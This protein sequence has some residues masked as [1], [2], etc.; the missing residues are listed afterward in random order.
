MVKHDADTVCRLSLCLAGL[1]SPAAQRARA[2]IAPY[3]GAA[4]AH[5]G[6]RDRSDG[7]ARTDLARC[8]E[9]GDAQAA[10]RIAEDNPPGAVGSRLLARVGAALEARGHLSDSLCAYSRA[11]SLN[12][13]DADIAEAG[14]AV[15]GELAV[16]S[17]R[18]AAPSI[19]D[20]RLS[21]IPGRILHVVGRSLPD[22]PG[23]YALRTDYAGSRAT[24]LRARCACRDRTWIP[25]RCP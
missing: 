22:T 18:W 3:A 9:V 20:R 25:G 23:G 14:E 10:W 19:G 8:L 12:P 2:L 5:L 17:G 15:R 24:R 16:L 11:A 13:D 7:S 1:G 21:P 4:T 6:P